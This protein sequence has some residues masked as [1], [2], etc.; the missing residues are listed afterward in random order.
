MIR[1]SAV[2]LPIFSA[3]NCTVPVVFS[4]AAYTGSPAF[5]STGML[6]PVSIDSSIEVCPSTTVPSTGIF[7]PGLTTS[8]SPIST[9]SIGISRSAPFS[10]RIA[11]FGCRPISFLIASLVRPF[12]TASSDFPSSI[13]A[14]MTPAVSKYSA[15]TAAKWPRAICQVL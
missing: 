10:R 9:S 4:D 14:M 15:S 6:S 7:A 8:M 3:L 13:S 1:A 5:L 2:S 11:V 12:E